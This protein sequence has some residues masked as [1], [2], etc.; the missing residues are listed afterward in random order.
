[1]LFLG[2]IFQRAELRYLLSVFR[3]VIEAIPN[4]LKSDAVS[5]LPPRASVYVRHIVGEDDVLGVRVIYAWESIL[6]LL[7]FVWIATGSY[8]GK[9]GHSPGSPT[10]IYVGSR[11]LRI[12]MCDG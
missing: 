2:L 6:F 9:G 10:D 7:D 11:A 12:Y 3:Y 8:L 1:M 4:L 5:I